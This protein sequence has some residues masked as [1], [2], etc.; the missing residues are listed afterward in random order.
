[1]N[2]I[3]VCNITFVIWQ[4]S[5]SKNKYTTIQIHKNNI[6]NNDNDYCTLKD[7]IS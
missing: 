1:M 3:Y 2:S 4:K 5:L 6:I 7:K